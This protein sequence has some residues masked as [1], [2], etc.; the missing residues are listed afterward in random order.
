MHALV[1]LCINQHR[2]FEVPNFTD[3]KDI[4][5]DKIKKQVMWPWPCPLEGIPPSEG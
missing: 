3:A 4:I 2:K 5:V 1:L